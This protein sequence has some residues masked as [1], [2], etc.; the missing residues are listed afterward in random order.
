MLYKKYIDF[1]HNDEEGGCCGH[2]HG[3]GEEHHCCGGHGHDHGEGHHCHHHEQEA[4]PADR[5]QAMMMYMI[6]HNA[7]HAM[8]I[9]NLEDSVSE[10]AALLMEQAVKAMAIS[11][12]F[13]QDALTILQN[14]TADAIAA[15]KAR[16]DAEFEK[17]N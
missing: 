14:E 6:N 4:I 3:E 12:D 5:T 13:L 11:C 8:E 16:A 15:E 1:Y 2:H 17:E 9:R 7:Q 10:D